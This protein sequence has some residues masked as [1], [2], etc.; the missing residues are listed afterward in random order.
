M[1]G[2]ERCSA[3]VYWQHRVCVI[4][5]ETKNDGICTCGLFQSR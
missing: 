3:C 5:G 2:R 4:T 1:S